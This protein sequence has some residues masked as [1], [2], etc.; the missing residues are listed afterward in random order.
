MRDKR[1]APH[2]A[3]DLTMLV[4]CVTER[5]GWAVRCPVELDVFEDQLVGRAISHEHRV[6]ETFVRQPSP[7]AGWQDQMTARISVDVDGSEASVA[8]LR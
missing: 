1:T 3:G 6:A 2:R 8:A 4:C 5:A 7:A